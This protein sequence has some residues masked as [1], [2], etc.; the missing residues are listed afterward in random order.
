MSINTSDYTF[1]TSK[2]TI[3][4]TTYV[5][6]L[7]AIVNKLKSLQIQL[8]KLDKYCEQ[9]GMD[10]RI[11]KC[12]IIGCPKKSKMN[13][14]AFKAQIQATNITYKNQAIPILHQNEQYVYLGIQLVP[15]LK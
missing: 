2:L 5:D 1:G 3:R 12:A 4:S 14:K 8:S 6:D 13:Q 11:T 7:V 15:L 9:I 10:L